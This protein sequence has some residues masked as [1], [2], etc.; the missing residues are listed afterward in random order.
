VFHQGNIIMDDGNNVNDHSISSAACNTVSTVPSF[1]CSNIAPSWILS[2]TAKVSL[3]PA[4]I[5]IDQKENNS[6]RQPMESNTGNCTLSHNVGKFAIPVPSK[7]I[8]PKAVRDVG[9]CN[10]MAL[11]LWHHP[12]NDNGL[13]PL[14]NNDSI[15]DDSM[16]YENWELLNHFD[17]TICTTTFRC[18][19]TIRRNSSC[20]VPVIEATITCNNK[21]DND[22]SCLAPP[23]TRPIAVRPTSMTVPK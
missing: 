23:L 22:N 9:C 11:T 15:Q 10:P 12:S 8:D 5:F 7:V 17:S 20:F 6:N 21:S 19:S 1:H 2:N 3:Q 16:V 4:D 14:S 18:D 13:P